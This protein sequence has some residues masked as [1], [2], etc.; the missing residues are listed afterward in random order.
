MSQVLLSGKQKSS[1]PTAREIFD[2]PDRYF[3]LLTAPLDS[4]IEGQSIDRK[5]TPTPSGNGVVQKSDFDNLVGQ[6]IETVSAFANANRTGGLLVI[7]IAKDGRILGI[8]HLNE[9]SGRRRSRFRREA[10]QDSGRKPITHSGAK[11]ISDSRLKAISKSPASGMVIGF[12]G[13]FS[14]GV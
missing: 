7:G 3:T 14:T 9:E 11:P 10:D 13:M 6:E 2:D 8:D 12:S 5:Q 1:M 4:Q